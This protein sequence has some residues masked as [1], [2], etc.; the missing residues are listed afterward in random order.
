M[1]DCWLV[2]WKEIAK[3]CGVCD[4]TARKYSQDFK[5][6]VYRRFGNVKALKYELDAWLIKINEKSSKISRNF[7]NRFP[8]TSR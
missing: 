8:K 5:M 7:P 2:G 1:D 3:Y 4:K 6:P